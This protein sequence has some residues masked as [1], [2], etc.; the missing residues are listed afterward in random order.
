[1]K[2]DRPIPDG[3][4]PLRSTF[5]GK[6]CHLS[7]ME[8]T[9]ADCDACQLRRQLNELTLRYED[10]ITELS[11]IQEAGCLLKHITDFT[12]VCVNLLQ[13]V[14]NNTPADNCSIMLLD[15]SLQKLFLVAANDKEGRSFVADVRDILEKRR[16]RYTFD[17]DFGVAGQAI[18][19]RSTVLVEDT[20][21]TPAFKPT[22]YETTIVL[23][24][25]VAV[26]LV[27]EGSVFGV[28]HLSHSQSHVFTASDSHLFSIISSFVALVI[29]TSLE[30]EKLKASEEKYRVLSENSQDGIAV[31]AG[32]YHLYANRKYLELTGY[33]LQ[34]LQTTSFETL[35]SKPGAATPTDDDRLSLYELRFTADPYETQLI[36]K[37]GAVFDVEVTSS[38]IR[39]D[40]ERE[41]MVC[42]RD[43]T[44]R[45]QLERQLWQSQKLEALGTLAGGIAHDFNN[46]LTGISGFSELSLFTCAEGSPI[47]SNLKKIFQAS[48]RAKHLIQQILTFS[49]GGEQQLQPVHI[50]PLVKECLQLLRS[51]LPTSIDIRYQS[52]IRTECVMANPTQMHQVIMN[53]STNAAHAMRGKG[54]VLSVALHRVHIDEE[55][56]VH[57]MDLAS[58]DYARLAVSDTGHGMTAEIM[59]NI[60]DPY[61]STK[62]KGEGTGL[63]LAVVHGIVKSHGGKIAVQSEPGSGSTFTVYVPLAEAETTSWAA[64]TQPEAGAGSETVLLVDDEPAIV[65]IGKAGLH[66]YGYTVVGLLDSLEALELF[67]GNPS[68]F[69]IVITDMTMPH[70]P[71]D[72]LARQ[73]LEIRP[74][75]PIII[76]SGYSDVI[77]DEKAK[78]IGVKGFLLKPVILENLASLVR[79]LLD[80]A[81][82]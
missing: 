25:L 76:C 27:V 20:L 61:F 70:L 78:A 59:Q 29:H 55:T 15:R 37:T 7:D 71:G 3:T 1:L 68:S 73:I 10:K 21:Q 47:E 62:K 50:K 8:T 2:H 65:E 46:I 44:D 82:S 26:P 51:S 38:P 14:L 4:V 66:R 75:M 69:D 48:Q 79:T 81:R 13:V 6:E 74:D 24:S 64:T 12:L 77:N 39:H 23:G 33:V 5:N 49:R 52:D 16:L 67:K 35:R 28:L 30:Q 9:L 56:G 41:M 31:M 58:G 54:G 18:E 53:L 45:K 22:P 36:S 17:A 42:L 43:I 34:E 60:F 72:L 57:E 63:G 80:E 32:G 11:T 40:G 19:T